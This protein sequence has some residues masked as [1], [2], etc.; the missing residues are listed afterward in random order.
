MGA[1]DDGAGSSRPAALRCGPGAHRCPAR[2]LSPAP[3]PSCV[4]KLTP[5]FACSIQKRRSQKFRCIFALF[6]CQHEF[7]IKASLNLLLQLD[8]IA[9]PSSSPARS[10][11][12]TRL[13]ALSLRTAHRSSLPGA[14]V[15]GGCLERPPRVLARSILAADASTVAAFAGRPKH[16]SIIRVKPLQ[17]NHLNRRA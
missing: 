16:E 1:D 13:P 12:G 6:N 14:S 7:C 9:N 3:Q 15:V 17:K 11:R 4:C 8:G 5:S 10:L 2:A